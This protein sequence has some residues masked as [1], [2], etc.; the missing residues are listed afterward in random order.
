LLH[1]LLFGDGHD[2]GAFRNDVAQ[3]FLKPIIKMMIMM[4]MKMIKMMITMMMITMMIMMV[5]T[6]EHFGMMQRNSS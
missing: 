3:F 5:M 1:Q 4:M 2:R 6:E